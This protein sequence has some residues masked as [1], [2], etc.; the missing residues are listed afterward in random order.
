MKKLIAALIAG[1]LMLSLFPAALAQ[2]TGTVVYDQEEYDKL[3][4]FFDYVGSD[5]VR[6]GDRIAPN[7]PPEDPEQ[8]AVPA[9]YDIIGVFWSDDGHE[10]HVTRIDLNSLWLEGELDLSDFD[11]LEDVY[12]FDNRISGVD[13][14]GSTQLETLVCAM[15]MITHIELENTPSLG[16]LDIEENMVSSLDLSGCP[17]LNRLLCSVNEL[18]ELD[19]TGCPR[20][21]TLACYSNILTEL[22]LTKCP[23]LEYLDCSMN[24]LTELDISHN[25]S[26]QELTVAD[27]PLTELD[28]NKAPNLLSLNCSSTDITELDLSRHEMLEDL[29]CSNTKVKKLDLRAAEMLVLDEVRAESE[30]FIGYVD[31]GFYTRVSARPDE[32]SRFIGWYN[33]AGELLSTD[34]DFGGIGDENGDEEEPGPNPIEMTGE[35]VWI[36]RFEDGGTEPA[37]PEPTE[38]GEPEPIEPAPTEIVS[39]GA[40]QSGSLSIA[41]LG[42][43]AVIAGAGA[44]IAAKKKND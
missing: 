13:V 32:G 31:N 37:E 21:D 23:E 14:S 5:G 41:W 17:G 15:N 22:D 3:M 29:R 40:P 18:E 16:E 24:M 33:E 9:A 43:A 35:K 20:L 25:R 19:V 28:V 2:G 30:G 26:L 8:W 11:W 7:F 42:L 38:P 36:A 4:A 10:A 6:N 12:C 1:I 44:V 39:P 34:P 27:N